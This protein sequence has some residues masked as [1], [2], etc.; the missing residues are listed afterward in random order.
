MDAAEDVLSIRDQGSGPGQIGFD[1]TNVRYSGT[2]IGAASGGSGGTD[3][4][5]SLN[6]NATPTAVTALVRNITY[7]NLD[8]LSPTTGA[9][10]VRFTV[11]DGDG[12]VVHDRPRQ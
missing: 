8:T 1:G 10:T 4:V 12:G 9:R 11:D 7:E 6:N 5:V 2:L 3:L